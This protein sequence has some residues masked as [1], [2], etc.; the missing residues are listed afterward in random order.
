MGHGNP[1]NKQINSFRRPLIVV[2]TDFPPQQLFV[3]V[4][5]VGF[6]PT[7]ELRVITG[8]PLSKYRHIYL[9]TRRRLEPTALTAELHT[10]C[11]ASRNRTYGHWFMRPA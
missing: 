6:A 11:C 3:M 7:P 2:V 1:V 8:G 4:N 5:M 10:L 9:A